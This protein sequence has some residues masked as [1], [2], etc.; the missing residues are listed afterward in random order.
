MLFHSQVFLLTFLP[1]TVFAYYRLAGHAHARE[2]LLVAASLLFYG[3]W[4]FRFIPLLVGQTVTSWLFAELY[5]RCPRKAVMVLAIGAN[6]GILAVYKYLNFLLETAVGITG[7]DLPRSDLVLPIGI[8]FYTFQIIS[9]L[10]DLMRGDAPRYGFRRFALFV[11]LFPQLVA[12]PIVRHNEIMP[13]F[14]L[15]PWR[16]GVAERIG[17]GLVLFF[18]GF[19][20]KVFIADRL[21]QIVDSVYEIAGTKIPTFEQASTAAIGFALQVFFDFAA[22]SNMAIGVGLVFGLTFP[23]NFNVPYRALDL[24]DLWGRWHMTLTRFL[25]D[26]VFLPILRLRRGFRHYAFATLATM[27]LCGLWHGAGWNFILWGLAQGAGIV[28]CRAWRK[29]GSSLPAFPAWLATIGFFTLTGSLLFRPADLDVAA[30]MYQAFTGQGGVGAMPSL[31]TAGLIT[32][33]GT[34]SMLKP[35]VYEFAMT[36]L[37]PTRI[38]VIVLTI[39]ALACVLEVGEEQPKSFIYFQF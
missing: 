39:V 38:A 2:W 21:A 18:A 5:F 29:S 11:M 23:Q 15:D 14:D 13:Q 1:A 32:V 37:R 9:Y 8:S 6:L 22:Y 34:F 31:E 3:W 10:A 28:L 17:R 27:G 7:F 36:R 25:R 12:G 30:R 24:I 16:S 35:S 26:Y 4:D 33:A 19:V 20:G